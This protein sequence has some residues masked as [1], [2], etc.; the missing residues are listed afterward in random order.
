MEGLGGGVTGLQGFEGDVFGGFRGFG[1]FRGF[2]V[3]G[4]GFWDPTCS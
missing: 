2:G 1:Q 4:K 3:A